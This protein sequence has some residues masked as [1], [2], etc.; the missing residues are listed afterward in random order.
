[1]ARR[2][3]T[4]FAPAGAH[5]SAKLSSIV[6]TAKAAGREPYAYVRHIFEKRPKAITRA[7]I[8]GLLPWNDAPPMR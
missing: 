2:R 4:R 1:M 5:A 3:L 8:E 7:D 6:E